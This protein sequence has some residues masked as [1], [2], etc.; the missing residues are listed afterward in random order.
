MVG[1]KTTDI[2]WIPLSEIAI[3]Y[4]KSPRMIRKWVHS[5]FILEIGFSVQRDVTGHYLI[6]VPAEQY[7]NFGTNLVVNQT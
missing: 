7:R 4:R 3:E 2:V 5:G 1:K 6:G